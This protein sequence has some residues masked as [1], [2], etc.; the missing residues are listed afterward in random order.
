MEKKVCRVVTASHENDEVYE[1]GYRVYTELY[2]KI[3]DLYRVT[4]NLY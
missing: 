2:P 4:S 1:R 3:K